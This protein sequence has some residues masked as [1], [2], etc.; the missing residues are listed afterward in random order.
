MAL[1]SQSKARKYKYPTFYEPYGPRPPAFDKIIQFTECIAALPT[2]EC[3]QIGPTLEVRLTHPKMQPISV[4]GVDLG[5]SSGSA[6]AEKKAKKMAFD[7]KLE[8]FDV[9]AKIKMIKEI[10]KVEMLIGHLTIPVW[11]TLSAGVTKWLNCQS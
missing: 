4:E 2:K 8:N 10:R 1:R 9:A 11:G 6:E 7:V 5:P 3:N